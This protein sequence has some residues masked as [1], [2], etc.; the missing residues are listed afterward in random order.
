MSKL[1]KLLGGV[2]AAATVAAITA[3][4]ALADPI[5][6]NGKPVTPAASDAV[7]VGSD[8]IEYLLDQLSVNYNTSHGRPFLYSWDA[9][10]PANGAVGDKITVKAGC[11]KIARPNGSSAGI[12]ALGNNTKVGSHFCI[13]YARS[14]R[15]RTPLD[16]VAGPGGILFVALAKDAVTYATRT[17]AHGG[18]NAPGNLSTANLTKIYNCTVT[19]WKAV[20]GKNAPI[21]PFLPQTGSG[22]RAFFL[23][24]I[25]VTSPGTCVNSS[26]QENEGTNKL[27]NSANAIV[28]FSIAKYIAEVYHSA[29][30]GHRPGPGQNRF[31]CDTHGVLGLNK[32]NGK[33]PTTGKAPNV[34]INPGFSVAFVRT[35]YDVVRWTTSTPDHIP[36]Y[37]ERFFAS[38][39]AKTK[40]YACNT[41]AGTNAI[42]NYGFLP[43]PLCGSGS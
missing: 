28:P 25:G 8:T 2:A 19:N 26:V 31:G 9:T 24:A 6:N 5:G 22:T 1:I 21:K 34:T 14:S 7:G 43:T 13:D 16:P 37:L 38:K 29:P 27:L 41:A 35:V 12:S 17:A 10:N 42:K 3:G 33:A 18:T 40:G 4:P 11:A 32:I 20:G 15:G 30:C 36:G 23:K 39:S